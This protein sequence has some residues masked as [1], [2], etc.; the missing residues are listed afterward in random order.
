MIPSPLFE[1]PVYGAPT[2][3]TIIWNREEKKW[4]LLY[5]QRRVTFQPVGFSDV[6][7]SAIGVA[8]SEDGKRWL[9]RGTLPG[10]EIEPGHNTFWAPEVLYAEG[11]YHMFV[12]YITG[13]PTDWDY[14][15]HI[16]HYTADNLWHWKYEGV[17]PL[18]S[19]RVIDACVFRLPDGQYKMWY[20]DEDHE[21]HSYAAVSPDLYHWT[22]VGDEVSYN[23]HEGP[24][25][26]SFGGKNWM[27]TDEWDGLGVYETEDFRHF[28]RNGVI[29]KEPGNRPQDARLGHHA[30][31][32]VSGGRAYIFYF[33]HPGDGPENTGAAASQGRERAVVQAAELQ[34]IDGKLV[35]DR[36]LDTELLL[37]P[38]E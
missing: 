28:R 12:S 11:K 9:Y 19:E 26:F 18:S 8:S 36:D 7:G 32:L 5:T 1:D 17:V 10:L 38:E 31:V 37:V 29:L 16:L 21:S 27:I 14:P 30:D 24:N 3:P 15:R 20:K 22:V 34:V 33:C 6:H 4:W 35:C 23:H 13:I 25:V 2:D